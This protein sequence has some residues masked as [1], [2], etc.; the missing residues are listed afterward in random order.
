M[1][2]AGSGYALHS[3]TLKFDDFAPAYLP[4][5]SQIISGTNKPTA[6][7]PVTAFPAPAPAAPYATN[8]ANFNGSNPNGTWSLF[9][10]DDSSLN[11]GA[12]SN[13]WSLNL[14]TANPVGTAG[15]VAIGMTASPSV[16]SVS[17]N[18]N[19]ILTVTNYG[20]SAA[21]GVSVTNT[22]PSGVTFVSAAG[23]QGTAVQNGSLVTWNIGSLAVNAGAQ[24]TITVKS[25]VF[26]M[27]NN[28]AHVTSTSAD[29]NPD[30]DTASV[31]VDVSLLSAPV[32]SGSLSETNGVFQFT[33]TGTPDGSYIIQASTNL[34]NWIPIYT[35]ISPFIFTD[36]Y[37]SN[38]PSRFYRAL[39]GP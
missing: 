26:G 27:I 6:Y 10:I 12:I 25:A 38:Y 1:A 16:V 11:S 19:F 23:T 21:N 17:N 39:V 13:G 33:L 24:L 18:L 31:A 2:N 7:F 36:P 14:V 29:P 35:N 34:V 28:S 8:M 4:Q 30:D 32:L 15:D 22:L 9:V 37:A 3:A 5:S 20:P